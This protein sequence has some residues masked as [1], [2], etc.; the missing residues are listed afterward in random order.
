MREVASIEVTASE[1][2]GKCLHIQPWEKSMLTPIVKGINHHNTHVGHNQLLAQNGGKFV[3]VSFPKMTEAF[4]AE[5]SKR[6]KELSTNYEGRILELRRKLNS[7][8]KEM[9]KDGLSEDEHDRA[10]KEVQS[11]IKTHID[12]L[13][14]LQEKKQ[15]EVMTI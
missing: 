1:Q 5:V 9:V 11:L 15:R 3:K 14:S 12:K 2:G 6:L 10:K 4:R 7:K 13:K 8:L